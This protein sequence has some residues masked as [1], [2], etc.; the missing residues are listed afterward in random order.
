[1]AQEPAHEPTQE[2][3]GGCECR[4]QPESAAQVP[5]ILLQE[6]QTA[7]KPWINQEPFPAEAG[8][9]TAAL[10][11][12]DPAQL[13]AICGY[14]T[15][16]P[17]DHT[18]IRSSAALVVGDKRPCR[19]LASVDEKHTTYPVS[20]RGQRAD[21]SGCQRQKGIQLGQS[22]RERKPWSEC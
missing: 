7:L 17:K 13:P 2:K 22:K 10:A 4:Y 9:P 6:A 12:V 8:T 19:P 5:D 15:T 11:G 14:V 1:M 18:L 3:G 21:V 20:A 16:T